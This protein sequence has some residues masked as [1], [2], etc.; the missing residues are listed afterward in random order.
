MP[1]RNLPSLISAMDILSSNLKAR[2]TE[3]PRLEPVQ[4]ELEAW[5]AETRG[6]ENAQ[7]VFTARL[8]ETNERRRLATTR[9][10]ELFAQ[11]DAALRGQLGT[12]N[13]MLHEFGLRP[14]GGPRRSKKEEPAPQPAPASAPSAE[15]K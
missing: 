15:T 7:E 6:L 9:G 13:K 10:V 11:A 3:F 12:K 8:R 5:L 1:E 2:L 4:A 14:R